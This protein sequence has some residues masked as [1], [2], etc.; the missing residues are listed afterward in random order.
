MNRRELTEIRERAELAARSQAVSDREAQRAITDRMLL[1]EALLAVRTE[2]AAL[3]DTLKRT[4]EVNDVD[5]SRL[6]QI[7]GP[8]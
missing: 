2:V 4:W 1:L 5:L 8:R 6:R 3:E 7:V